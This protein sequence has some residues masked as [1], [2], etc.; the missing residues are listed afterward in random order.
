MI[1]KMKVIEQMWIKILETDVYRYTDQ[2]NCVLKKGTM[3]EGNKLVTYKYGHIY[4]RYMPMVGLIKG[5]D[6]DVWKD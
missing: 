3:G 4:K 2:I 5:Y 6:D 1:H